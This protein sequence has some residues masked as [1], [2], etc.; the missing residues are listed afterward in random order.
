MHPCLLL[1]AGESGGGFIFILD[2]SNLY[3][4][5]IT[6]LAQKISIG[7]LGNR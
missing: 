7:L 4:V 2:F 6:K 1:M 5:V 3:F